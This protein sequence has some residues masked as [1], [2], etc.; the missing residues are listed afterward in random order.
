MK[1][2]RFYPMVLEIFSRKPYSMVESLDVISE[3]KKKIGYA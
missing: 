3:A 1:S 2:V